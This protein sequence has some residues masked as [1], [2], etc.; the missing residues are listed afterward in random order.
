MLAAS[1]SK[2]L[3]EQVLF[4]FVLKGFKTTFEICSLQW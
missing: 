3:L 2:V 4:G 1:V